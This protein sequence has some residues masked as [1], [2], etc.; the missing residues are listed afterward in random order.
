MIGIETKTLGQTNNQ[1]EGVRFQIAEAA[2]LTMTVW[3]KEGG[4]ICGRA[5]TERGILS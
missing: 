3:R 2:M 4:D 5:F 1:Y